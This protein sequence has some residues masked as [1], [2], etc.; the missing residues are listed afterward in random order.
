MS[1]K[2]FVVVTKIELF[3]IECR[4]TKS[5]VITMAIRRKGKYP[6]ESMRTQRKRTK[7]P[8]AREDASDRVVIGFNISSDWWRGGASFLGQSQSEFY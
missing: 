1:R 2:V 6:K 4:K 3:A 8:Q 5:K 7:F